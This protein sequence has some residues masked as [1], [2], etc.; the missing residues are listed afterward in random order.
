MLQ[1]REPMFPDLPHAVAHVLGTLAHAGHEAALVGGAVRDR[2]LGASSS[3]TD[4]DVATSATPDDVAPLFAGTTWDNRFGTVTVRGEPD[5]EVTSYRTERGYG[6]RRRPDEVRFGASLDE[7]LARR[8]FTIN[9]IA[10]IPVALDAGRGRVVDPFDGI[11]DLSRRLLRAVGDPDERFSEDALRLVRGA[12]LAGRFDLDIEPGTERAIT[13]LAGTVAGVSAERV[14]DEVLRMLDAAAP[15][16]SISILERLGLLAVMLPELAALRGVPQ[17]KATPGD[18]LDHTLRAVDASPPDDRTLR[19]AALLH[20]IGKASTLADGHFIGHD[21][22]GAEL[23]VSILRRLRVPRAVS[24]EVVDAVRHHMYAYDPAWTDA[25]VRRFVRRVG[26]DRLP[27]LFGLRR[28]DDAASGVGTAGAE[29]QAALEQR[30]ALE[31]ERAPDLLR[32]RKLAIDGDDVQGALGIGPGPRVGVI[33]DGLLEAVLDNPSLNRRDEL[34]VL[35]R[36]IGRSAVT[37]GNGPGPAG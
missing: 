28:A 13:R 6:D 15:S 22:V 34:L 33:M 32:G 12:R 5:V 20:D 29:I 27:L 1:P 36:R 8:D 11:G 25:A 14:R 4:W 21:R 3:A 26:Q 18:A 10:W 31:V 7:D 17:A 23:A 24:D 30:I 37:D 35:A 16:V 9:A 2:V 19:L